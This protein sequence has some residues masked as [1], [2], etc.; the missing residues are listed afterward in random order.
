MPL[1]DLEDVGAVTVDQARNGDQL[2]LKRL[3]SRYG[4]EN[5]IVVSAEPLTE[6]GAGGPVAVRLAARRA[7]GSTRSGR[8]F[9]LD[10]APGESLDKVLETAV[11]RIQSSLDEQWKNTHILRLDTG[12]LIFVDIPIRTLADWVKINR[13]LENL[14]EVSQVEIA[15]FAQEL[16]R[17]QIYYVGDEVGFEQALGGLGLTLSREGESWLLLPTATN[18]SRNVPL[19]GTSTAS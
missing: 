12:G 18:P 17:A 2:A 6:A 1:G 14:P 19:S 3:A 11:L 4:A 9:D 15:S 5:A 13:D 8:P 16:V 10:G 7:G